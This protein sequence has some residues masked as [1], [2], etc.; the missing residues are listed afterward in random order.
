MKT[1]PHFRDEKTEPQNI[2]LV[3][4]LTNIQQT[5]IELCMCVGVCVCVCGTVPSV[6]M[7]SVV[8]EVPLSLQQE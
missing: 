2:F 5:Y 3:Q 1:H 7:G 6:F 4:G 8:P